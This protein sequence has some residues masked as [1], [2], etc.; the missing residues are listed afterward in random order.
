MLVS[1]ARVG[2]SPGS[3][4][5]R[6]D[7]ERRLRIVESALEVIEEHGI[8]ALT[9]RAVAAAADVPLGSTTY[10]FVDKDELLEATVR[11]ARER[12]RDTARVILADAVGRLG[13]SGGIAHLV[14]ELT[15]H[16]HDRLVLE[17]D[18]YLAAIHRPSLRAESRRWSDDFAE[19][20]GE[21]TDPLTGR[22]V[23]LLFDGLCLRAAVLDHR[24]RAAD[25]E[26]LVHRLLQG[27]RLADRGIT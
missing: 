13:L 6:Y 2:T 1:T 21:Y 12:S 16:R 27:M 8:A 11:L 17:H 7:P 9:F 25:V 18:L 19:I 4:V 5:R 23:G 26:P 3:R 24:F 14:E 10:H 15:Y 22:T 20:V